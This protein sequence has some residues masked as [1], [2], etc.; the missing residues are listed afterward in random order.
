MNL[1]Q[2]GLNKRGISLLTEMREKKVKLALGMT[3]LGAKKCDKDQSLSSA[4]LGYL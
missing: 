2:T 3:Y 1:I 4:S